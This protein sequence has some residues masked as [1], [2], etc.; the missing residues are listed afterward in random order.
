VVNLLGSDADDGDY[1][2][3]ATSSS[4]DDRPRNT[5]IQ[6]KK[7]TKINDFLSSFIVFACD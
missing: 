2:P 5:R 1:K 7:E 3:G 6:T 4:E